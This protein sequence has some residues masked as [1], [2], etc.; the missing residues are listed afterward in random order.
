MRIWIIAAVSA[1]VLALPYAGMAQDM[2]QSTGPGTMQG[3]QGSTATG[4]PPSVGS[5]EGQGSAGGTS[6][7]TGK[8]G[9]KHL[10][11]KGHKG[12]KKKSMKEPGAG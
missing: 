3:D 1:A 7:S 5:N 8:S 9:K 4:A 12:G 11:G 6:P 2:G 10:K